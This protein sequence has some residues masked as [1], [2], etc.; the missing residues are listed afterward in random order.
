MAGYE[1]F[2]PQEFIKL[3]HC[4]AVLTLRYNVICNLATN[5]QERI[6]NNPPTS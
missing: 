3:L 5:D 2:S 1:K 6:Y 4:I